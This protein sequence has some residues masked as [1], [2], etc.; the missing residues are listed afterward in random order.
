MALLVVALAACGSAA[1]GSGGAPTAGLAVATAPPPDSADP[2][3]DDADAEAVHGPVSANSAPED[4]ITEALTDAGV[5]NPAR[6][7]KQVVAHRPYPADDPKLTRLRDTLAA[8]RVAPETLDK[9]VSA[10][11]P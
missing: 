2:D 10:L 3:E 1:S 6:W 11:K 4:E 9:I 7:A 8:L 5:G